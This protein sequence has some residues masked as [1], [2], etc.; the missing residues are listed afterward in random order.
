MATG[1]IPP[2]V[3]IRPGPQNS[4][5]S[6]PA[7]HKVGS[8][9][10]ST[11]TLANSHIEETPGHTSTTYVA[12]DSSLGV[13][14][15]GASSPS[16]T[17]VVYPTG[18][19]SHSE[20]HGDVKNCGIG[21]DSPYKVTETDATSGNVYPISTT[22]AETSIDYLYTTETVWST[23]I[24]LVTECALSAESCTHGSTAMTT[25]PVSTTAY[26]VP[27]GLPSGSSDY[28][29]T[30][31]STIY[32]TETVYY[33]TIHT[34]SRDSS[35]DCVHNPSTTWTSPSSPTSPTS[36]EQSFDYATSVTTERQKAPDEPCYPTGHEKPYAPPVVLVRSEPSAVIPYSRPGGAGQGTEVTAGTTRL[37]VQIAVVAVM[38][39]LAALLS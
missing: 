15:T 9:G 4:A 38:G 17:H 35:C 31:R 16:T 33:T 8:T 37:S 11:T 14:T 24:Y 26:R 34:I 32:I 20:C 36:F 2:V 23:E 3:Y 39:I 29:Y 25:Y 6:V 21:S 30:A 28:V 19:K 10:T 12:A 18:M 22:I 1:S 13:V 27:K 5:P 7:D